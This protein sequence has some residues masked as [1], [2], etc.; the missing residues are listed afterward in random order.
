MNI[1]IERELRASR[2]LYLAIQGGKKRGK[3]RKEKKKKIGE[4]KTG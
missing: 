1:Y 4:T 3:K 2:V